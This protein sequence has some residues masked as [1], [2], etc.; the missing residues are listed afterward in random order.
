ME[1]YMNTIIITNNE[2]AFYIDKVYDIMDDSLKQEYEL[3]PQ[4]VNFNFDP[5]LIL[6]APEAIYAVILILKL[7]YD[8]VKNKLKNQNDPNL[9]NIT[10]VE[11]NNEQN[12]YN[13]KTTSDNINIQIKQKDNLTE[14]SIKEINE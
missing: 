13:I 5:I 2:A 12:T 10:S 7:G 3:L 9:S 14:L 1:D 8:V 11:F 6:A 4:R